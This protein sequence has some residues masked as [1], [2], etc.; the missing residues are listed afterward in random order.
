MVYLTCCC[1]RSQSRRQNTD[2]YYYCCIWFYY[3]ILWVCVVLVCLLFWWFNCWWLEFHWEFAGESIYCCCDWFE[4]MG[5]SKAVLF[6]KL[7]G[8]S[9]GAVKCR[10]VFC[11]CCF[12][13]LSRS[14]HSSVTF[15]RGTKKCKEC[16]SIKFILQVCFFTNKQYGISLPSQLYCN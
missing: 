2:S 15:F 14:F 6:I 13:A 5:R 10:V 8:F 3:W 12:N 11:C 16:S 1:L 9:V 7:I 4:T